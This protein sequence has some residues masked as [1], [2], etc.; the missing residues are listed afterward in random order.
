MVNFS[1][2]SFRTGMIIFSTIL[3][4]WQRYSNPEK[5]NAYMKI[6]THNTFFIVSQVVGVKS[7]NAGAKYRKNIPKSIN[8]N[9]E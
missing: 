4:H 8:H 2:P 7:Y 6:S 9:N 3:Q 1:A 5:P